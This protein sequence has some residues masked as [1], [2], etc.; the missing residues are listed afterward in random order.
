M[1]DSP[2][3]GRPR[4]E[5]AG[6]AADYLSENIE[7]GIPRLDLAQREKREGNRRVHVRPR[8]LAEV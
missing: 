4:Q 6:G 7:N 8:A 5:H 2:P 3:K 1:T